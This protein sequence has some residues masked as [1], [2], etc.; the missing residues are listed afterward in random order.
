MQY[1][2]DFL[3]LHV[4][5]GCYGVHPRRIERQCFSNEVHRYLTTKKS[6]CIATNGKR[7]EQ[8]SL[9]Y[10]WGCK[11]RRLPA[12]HPAP[13]KKPPSASFEGFSTHQTLHPLPP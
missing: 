3:R 5:R 8:G 4:E 7:P 6:R 10:P 13:L 2:P 1:G 9:H 11:E 12:F